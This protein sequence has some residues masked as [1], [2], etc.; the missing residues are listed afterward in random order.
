MSWPSISGWDDC[1][2]SRLTGSTSS[3]DASSRPVTSAGFRS[4]KP[5]SPEPEPT[6]KLK[7]DKRDGGLCKSDQLHRQQQQRANRPIGPGR[8]ER[9]LFKPFLLLFEQRQQQCDERQHFQPA[10]NQL[11]SVRHKEH[12]VQDVQTVLKG[13]RAEENPAD[14]HQPEGN[15]GL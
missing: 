13:N 11:R 6:S 12:L 5:L 2:I 3:W 8:P 10:W 1:S 14:H 4:R 9:D 15:Q 7:I